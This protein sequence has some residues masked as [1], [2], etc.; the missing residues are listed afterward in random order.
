MKTLFL[1]LSCA[2]LLFGNMAVTADA[3]ATSHL[4]PGQ[5]NQ[6]EDD[7]FEVFIDKTNSPT[8]LDPGDL[9]LGVIRI[10]AIQ[11]P[12]N[13][14]PAAYTPGGADETI[15]GVFLLEVASVVN[16]A[17]GSPDGVDNTIVFFKPVEDT[18]WSSLTGLNLPSPLDPNTMLIVYD[19]VI[20]NDLATGPTLQASI[21]SFVGS[22]VVYEFGFE[23]G[24]FS[25]GV[26][27]AGEFWAAHGALGTDTV[28]GQLGSI[29]NIINLNLLEHLGGPLLQDHTYLSTDAILEGFAV[30]AGVTFTA[31][32]ELQ[33]EG[34]ITN[35]GAGTP[36]QFATDTDA[37]VQA[38]IPEPS[39]FVLF[40]LGAIGLVGFGLRRRK[41]TAELAA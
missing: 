41:Q 31:A 34:T 33:A 6:L 7:N 9:I 36:W 17:G 25:D 3:G 20:V 13:T 2:I 10:Q 4:V 15:T 26:S 32:A 37:Y 38:I 5:V 24:D 8:T 28:G 22:S 1:K 27:D 23:G 16:Q 11:S 14:L 12:P 40:G 29:R 39:S 18:D 35:A 19:D 21:D 30:D